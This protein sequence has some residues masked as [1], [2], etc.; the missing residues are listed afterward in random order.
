MS[1]PKNPNLPLPTNAPDGTSP[2]KPTESAQTTLLLERQGLTLSNPG[3]IPAN[4]T[5]A[6][7][8][9]RALVSA[10]PARESATTMLLP[11]ISPAGTREPSTG[12]PPPTAPPGRPLPGSTESVSL[13]SLGAPMRD[14]TATMLFGTAV[15]VRIATPAGLQPSAPAD[16]PQPAAPTA[17]GASTMLLPVLSPTGVPSAS[18]PGPVRT[19]TPGFAQ[20]TG[21]SASG[22]AQG[23]SGHVRTT[24]P[25]FSQAASA[26]A[27]GLAQGGASGP[28]R[29]PTPASPPPAVASAAALA[30]GAS[31]PVRV[32]TPA[33][34]LPAASSG[35][36][37]GNADP[38]RTLTP[39][40]P[41]PASP[42]RVPV[43][44][45]DTKV[46]DA[47]TNLT[48]AMVPPVGAPR[49]M[50]PFAAAARLAP[51]PIVASPFLLPKAF[52][53]RL[54]VLQEHVLERA[55]AFRALRQRLAEQKDPR[56]ILVTSA[57][58]G[59][60]KTTCAANLALA[61]AES[62]RVSVLLVEASLR[63]PELS[64]LFGCHPSHCLLSQLAEHRKQIDAP[65]HTIEIQPSGLHV[66]AVAPDGAADEA[67]HS[68]TFSASM[69][70]WRLTFDY[71]VVDGPAILSSCD[72]SI[73]HDS[74]DAVVVVVRSGATRHRTLQRAL[75]QMS[76]NKVAGLVL[77]DS[78][79]K[80]PAF[81]DPS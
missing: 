65:W 59:E 39:A 16:L 21:A 76:A 28:V 69:A 8:D 61:L 14:P 29:V 60:G 79:A 19:T 54:V 36:S 24:T 40:R 4:P 38:V 51:A 62:G 1:D 58:D 32:P 15:P 3:S 48:S 5:A 56:A 13:A 49:A 81:Q 77:M 80:P 23:A 9:R 53:S 70:R 33:R 66:L 37:A 50:A 41:L 35:R 75:E 20:P 26:S 34:P 67:L 7:Q 64:K 43:A 31:A 72:A 44:G 17:E 78:P 25:G 6:L 22:V 10:V 42:V 27:S 30:P 74:M 11:A 45:T 57:H 46:R 73:I 68:P 71:V 12:A 2:F 52:D 63:R 55:A 18:S 47:T